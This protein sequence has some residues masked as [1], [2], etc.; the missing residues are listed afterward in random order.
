MEE[1]IKLLG[2]SPDTYF[3]LHTDGEDGTP[4]PGSSLAPP[5]PPC[6]LRSALTRYADLLTSPK[7]VIFVFGNY[8]SIIIL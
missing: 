7:K 1:A 5:F 8:L 6:N 3:S 2:V 4:L